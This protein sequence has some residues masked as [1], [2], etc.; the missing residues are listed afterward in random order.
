MQKL[1]T[2]ESVEIA[3]VSNL[4][5]NVFVV[6]PSDNENHLMSSEKISY[7]VYRIWKLLK[8]AKWSE[9]EEIYI[10]G[11]NKGMIAIPFGNNEFFTAVIFKYPTN[12]S[13][14]NRV[15]KETLKELESV[16]LG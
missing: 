10:R 14:I 2:I 11:E 4:S 9:M 16:I 5:E 1:K 7:L 6:V 15:I 8:N 3:I 12:L 13:L